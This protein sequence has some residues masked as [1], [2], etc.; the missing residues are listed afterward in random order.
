VTSLEALP[1]GHASN[2]SGS[3]Y[4]CK[5]GGRGLPAP[6]PHQ[7]Q[8][9][10]RAYAAA[11]VPPRVF[12]GFVATRD[13]PHAKHTRGREAGFQISRRRVLAKSEH[14]VD[15][16]PGSGAEELV[17]AAATTALA[18]IL[19]LPPVWETENGA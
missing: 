19:P 6:R 12:L 4:G 3:K 13:A 7:P 10:M 2:E 15:V 5:W 8:Q 17:A 14:R 11:R 9:Q 16:I 1:E 18:V